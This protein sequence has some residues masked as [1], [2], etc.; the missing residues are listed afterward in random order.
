MT[1]SFAHQVF[2][3]WMKGRAAES[4]PPV[5][6]HFN[7]SRDEQSRQPEQTDG[8][9]GAGSSGWLEN[10]RDAA[11]RNMPSNQNVRDQ[12]ERTHKPAYKPS[13]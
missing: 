5:H 10:E 9:S 1:K 13:R 4:V 8:Q 2:G 11:F 12:P 3:S 6:Y 7:Q